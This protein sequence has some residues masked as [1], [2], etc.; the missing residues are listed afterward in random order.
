VPRSIGGSGD[1]RVV[2]YGS[3]D[4]RRNPVVSV[5]SGPIS[6][7]LV[8]FLPD[9][10]EF[11]MFRWKMDQPESLLDSLEPFN[12]FTLSFAAAAG[13]GLGGAARR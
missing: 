13:G 10:I 12:R 6:L 8:D 7:T 4:L 11:Q 1:G 2:C 5:L 9:R 3:A